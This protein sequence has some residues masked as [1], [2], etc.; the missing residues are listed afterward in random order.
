MERT[1]VSFTAE[2]FETQLANIGSSDYSS[3]NT[4]IPKQDLRKGRKLCLTLK[5]NRNNRIRF[6][7]FRFRDIDG[8]FHN[9]A[10]HGSEWGESKFPQTR[11]AA[12]DAGAPGSTAQREEAGEDLRGREGEGEGDGWISE[13]LFTEGWC[14]PISKSQGLLSAPGTTYEFGKCGSEKD[15]TPAKNSYV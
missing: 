3:Q 1:C 7:K 2:K 8:R 11:F 13:G 4:N 5:N 9:H 14:K 12:T 10:K 6:P 15:Q